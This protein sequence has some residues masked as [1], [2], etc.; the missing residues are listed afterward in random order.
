MIVTDSNE[1]GESTAATLKRLNENFYGADPAD[2]FNVRWLA[3]MAFGA[4]PAQA[5]SLF[6]EGLTLEHIHFQLTDVTIDPNGVRDYVTVESQVLLHQVSE[7]LLRLFLAHRDRPP[8]PWLELAGELSFPAFKKRVRAEILEQRDTA[9]VDDVFLAW[10]ASGSPEK[11]NLQEGLKALTHFLR[12]LAERWLEDAHAYNSMKH[13]LSI[14]PSAAELSFMASTGGPAVQLG[15]G[16][17]IEF[18]ECS[19]WRKDDTREWRGTTIW[20]DVSETLALIQVAHGMM[21]SLWDIARARYTD[22]PAPD[23]VYL[24]VGLDVSKLRSPDAKPANRWSFSLLEER[25]ERS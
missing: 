6:S 17:S 8:C 9:A 18:L 24:P 22:A 5:L 16:P 14:V 19:P 7:T 21:T 1:D 3:L 2:Y 12:V 25:K 23:K 10:A 13:G 11:V 4:K 15:G 20:I